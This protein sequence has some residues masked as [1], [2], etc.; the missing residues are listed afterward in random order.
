[1]I[2]LK[3]TTTPELSIIV[4]VY[5][6][7]GN[8]LPLV[9]KIT[10]ALEGLDYEIIYVD[11]GSTDNTRRELRSIQN[12]RLTIIELQ[13][14]FGQSAALSAGIQEAQGEFI[15]TLDG[16]LQNDP[17]DIP[18]MLHLARKEDLDLVTGIRKKRKDNLV[19]KIPSLIANAFIRRLSGVKL[20]DFGCT[21]KVFRKKLAKEIHLYGELHRFIPVL[22][23]L[24][25]ARMKDVVVKHHP[26]IH[27]QAKYGMGRTLKV[28]SDLML[29]LFFKK[30]LARP[31]HLFGNLGIL[32][33]G[34]GLVINFYLL[35]L[36]LSGNSIWGK[37]LLMVGILLVIAGIQLVTVGI[38]IDIQMRTYYESQNKKPYK[39]RNIIN[40]QKNTPMGDRVYLK[41]G[42]QG[43]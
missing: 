4:C 42:D 12:R 39:I 31:M 5:N 34:A 22:A 1:M 26:R 6:E 13:K 8:I 24:E 29:L 25:G 10:N 41:R 27:G 14:N 2:T 28:I 36:K 18:A 30:Y 40:K 3:Q 43:L 20:K 23:Q 17:S 11:D 7:E 35:F 38:L 9:E 32:L 19:R 21:L 33:F 37:P 16:D 15:V